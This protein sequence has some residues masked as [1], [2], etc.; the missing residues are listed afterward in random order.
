M[1]KKD[2]H[3]HKNLHSKH[4]LTEFSRDF[5]S[6]NNESLLSKLLNKV[7]LVYSNVNQNSEASTSNNKELTTPDQNFS[8]SS[9]SHSK[10]T[11]E[12]P[13]E[14]VSLDKKASSTVRFK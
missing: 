10:S 14:I 1:D 8:A 7:T 11:V 4:L 12:N 3:S 9:G 5:D 2:V 6:L 13:R